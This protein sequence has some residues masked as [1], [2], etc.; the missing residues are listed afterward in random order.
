M[1]EVVAALLVAACALFAMLI[2]VVVRAA[3]C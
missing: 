3:A 2:A 1:R